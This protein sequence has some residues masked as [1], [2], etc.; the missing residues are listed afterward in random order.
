MFFILFIFIIV[1][2]P[3]YSVQCLYHLSAISKEV[4]GAVIV[5]TLITYAKMLSCS[6]GC[7]VWKEYYDLETVRSFNW[8]IIVQ[9][10]IFSSNFKLFYVSFIG[11]Y[12]HINRIFS[13][14]TKGKPEILTYH[15]NLNIFSKEE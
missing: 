1:G 7:V 15:D 11:I 5:F 3:I 12:F 13:R 6:Y 10:C 9:S 14:N 4:T 8:V 2:M